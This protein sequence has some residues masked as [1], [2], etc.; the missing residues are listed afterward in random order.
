MES[1]SVIYIRAKAY[2]QVA[3]ELLA[4]QFQK[5]EAQRVTGPGEWKRDSESTF[6]LRDF[7]LPYWRNAIIFREKTLHALAEYKLFVQAMQVYPIFARYFGTLVGTKRGGRGF[8][9]EDI[10]D[11]LLWAMAQKMGGLNFDPDEFDQLYKEFD[12]DIRRDDVEYVAVAPIV[13]FKS[14]VF[15]IS[16]D[17]DFEI[18]RLTDEEIIRCLRLSVY[19][20]IDLGGIIHIT[21]PCGVRHRFRENKL[22]GDI[23]SERGVLQAEQEFIVS[24]VLDVAH[25]LRLFKSGRVAIPSLVSFATHWPLNGGTSSVGIEPPSARGEFVLSAEEGKAF[26]QFWPKFI[27][28]RQTSFVD[29][30]IRRFGYA[31]ERFR[32]QDRLVDFMICAESLFLS[33]VGESKE[34][35]EMRFR[36]SLRFGLFAEIEGYSRVDAF[37]LMRSAYDSRSAIVHGGSVEESDLKLPSIGTVALMKF[38]EAVEEA[39]RSALH[40]AIELEPFAKNKLVDWDA[41]ALGQSQ[42]THGA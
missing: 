3:M 41:L 26:A 9:V 22:F 23:S 11:H 10:A 38:V 36:L 2:V 14:E 1:D 8:R 5:S 33:D 28:A 35:G 32:P 29:A 15:P 12:A 42:R 40:K 17:S 6:R 18:D 27:N 21:N 7:E 34:R 37:R 24:R 16:L 4:G 13:G 25:C 31:G 19:P 39:L 30:A 20:G